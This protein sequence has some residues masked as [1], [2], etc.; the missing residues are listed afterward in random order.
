MESKPAGYVYCARLSALAGK[1]CLGLLACLAAPA[2]ANVTM[3][4][5]TTNMVLQRSIPVPVWGLAAAGENVTVKFNG[6]TKTVK[7]DAGGKWKVTL[8]AMTAGGPFDMDVTGDNAVKFTN[9]MVGEVWVCSGQSNM[10]RTLSGIPKTFTA[11]SIKASNYPNIRQMNT[12]NKYW[13]VANAANI[14]GFTAVGFFM[15]RDLEKNLG[16]A[17]GLI[18]G[19]V[20]GTPIERWMIPGDS[21]AAATPD[22]Y[23]SWIAPV[24]GFGIRGTIWYQ[25]EANANGTA[26]VVYRNRMTV[27]IKGWRKVWKQGDFPFLWVQLANYQAVQTDPN[28]NSGW[29]LLREAQRLSL[30]NPNT[31]MAVTIDVGEAADIHPQD[32]L[33]VGRRLALAARAKAYGQTLVYSGPQY[34]SMKIDGAKIRLHFGHVGGGLVAK[35]GPL[36]GFV[37]AGADNKFQFATAAIEGSDVLVSHVSVTAPTQVRYAWANNPVCNLYNVEN[38]PASPFRTSGAQLPVILAWN[39]SGSNAAPVFSALPVLSIDVL[40]RV[41][42][43]GGVGRNITRPATIGLQRR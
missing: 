8:D 35:G 25:G 16:V 18:H 27:L 40:G 24:V 13:R 12:H 32:K 5:F 28:E 19:S 1:T 34:E 23:N 10:E 36:K 31:G 33:T 43:R 11:D 9:V 6:Q 15:A 3:P 21:G 42:V 7:A 29:A 22:L 38:I 2:S 26:D 20:G 30:S 17:I 37:V 4:Y 39:R 41:L 14:G